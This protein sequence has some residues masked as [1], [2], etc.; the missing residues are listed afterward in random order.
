MKSPAQSFLNTPFGEEGVGEVPVRDRRGDGVD[1]RGRSRRPA[2][3]SL[4]RTRRRRCPRAG[5]RVLSS[6]T[7]GR[8]GQPVDEP[9]DVG[10]LALRV[11]EP[12]LARWTCRS[13]A[14][15]R[16]ARRTRRG[17]APRPRRAR[18]PCCRRSRGRAGRRGGA[19]SGPA[20]KYEVSIAHSAARGHH[21]VAA[22]HGRAR[23]PRRPRPSTCRR[24]RAPRRQR[25]G[26]RPRA[27]A[28]AWP[29]AVRGSRRSMRQRYGR[30]PTT[31]AA[32]GLNRGTSRGVRVP[33]SRTRVRGT[34][35]HAEI[36]HPP[37][38]HRR[39]TDR[40]RAPLRR[41]RRPEW[42]AASLDAG[43]SSL[44]GLRGRRAGGLRQRGRDGPPGQG[45][46]DV[47]VRAGGG[48]AVP[49]ARHRPGAGRARSR[50][51]PGSAGCYGM[52]VGVD[53]GNDAALADV[54]RRG[55]PGRRWVRR[56][57]RGRSSEAPRAGR[58]G[59]LRPARPPGSTPAS[60]CPGAAAGRAPS[61][62]WRRR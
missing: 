2:A 24:P 21:P 51:W 33:P 10:D 54:S 36:R 14:P 61:R 59:G 18:R 45:D 8:F 27:T 22:L 3:R 47:P 17:R 20:V 1:P 50:R 38:A 44:P 35:R 60:G 30:P 32:P 15:T 13:R 16:S 31:G 29:R 37:C 9:G 4:R 56:R 28:V 42:S 11:V 62:G 41:S 23:R 58:A 12:D 57:R 43:P 6:R 34:K 26:A 5:R 19:R 48:R 39:R 49:A 55:R 25:G 46:R 52:W 53:T 7:S 40:R